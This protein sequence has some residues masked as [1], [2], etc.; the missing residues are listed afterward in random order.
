MVSLSLLH[1]RRSGADLTGVTDLPVGGLALN[2][3]DGK[4]FTRDQGNN[5][6]ELLAGNVDRLPRVGLVRFAQYGARAGQPAS[7]IAAA[8]RVAR[9]HSYI[10]N[11]IISNPNGHV[12]TE[13]NGYDS[14]VY[15]EVA[16][17]FK[18]SYNSSGRKP[19]G[20]SYG[21]DLIL[22][23]DF[24]FKINGEILH[25]DIDI[26]LQDQSCLEF[27]NSG[28]RFGT[29]SQV[30][31]VRDPSVQFINQLLIAPQA[32]FMFHLDYQD[33]V[34]FYSKDTIVNKGKMA[35]LNINNTTSGST[36]FIGMTGDNP[37]APLLV[38]SGWFY[39]AFYTNKI[40]TN[41]TNR[42]NEIICGDGS[43]TASHKGLWINGPIFKNDTKQQ[44]PI[45]LASSTGHPTPLK[46]NK[47]VVNPVVTITQADYD[48][49]ATKDPNLMYII[50]GP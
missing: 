48:A 46:V 5:V 16:Y 8:A 4:L 19:S 6:V 3:A 39:S 32:T 37:T 38:N 29:H 35:C 30:A 2:L 18:D 13:A 49:L 45:S 50:T 23:D 12:S 28:T 40:S 33:K 15:P 7:L 1:S 11:V 31:A 36:G 41:S 25:G 44:V 22:A 34:D 9:N 14:S 17:I 10:G 21:N 20:V 24:F 27:K 43:I 47:K 26:R 42:S